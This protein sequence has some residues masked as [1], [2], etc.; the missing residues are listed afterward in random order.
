MQD[1]TFRNPMAFLLAQLLGGLICL[2]Q[3]GAGDLDQFAVQVGDRFLSDLL[4]ALLLW[5]GATPLSNLPGTTARTSH[6]AATDAALAQFPG[7]QGRS[8][9]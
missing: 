6:T 2:V 8:G 7:Q 3:R 1:E 9:F 4:A 5:G